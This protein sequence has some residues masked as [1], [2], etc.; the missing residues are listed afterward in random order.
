MIDCIIKGKLGDEKYKD[1]K[2]LIE[3][4][5][6][7]TKLTEE[8]ENKLKEYKN[9]IEGKDKTSAADILKQFLR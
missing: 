3:K 9:I 5:G 8:E 4:N 1:F 2:S 6:K 7:G